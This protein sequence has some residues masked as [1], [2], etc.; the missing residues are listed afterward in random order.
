MS[1]TAINVEFPKL[2]RKIATDNKVDGVIDIW[3]P[4][5]KINGLNATFGGELDGDTLTCDGCHPKD[6][7][8]RIMAMEIATHIKAAAGR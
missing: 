5:M 6:A 1:E 8:L 4:L 3:T 7:G 2:Q